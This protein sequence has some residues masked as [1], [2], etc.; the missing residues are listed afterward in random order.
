MAEQSFIQRFYEDVTRNLDD[1]S[2]SRRYPLNK[3]LQDLHDIDQRLFEDVLMLSGQE[4][5]AGFAESTI[6][7][8][9]NKEFYRLPEGFRQFLALEFRET[10]NNYVLARI[11]SG[12]FFGLKR[13]AQI[14]TSARGMRLTPAVLYS[15][16][17]TTEEWTLVYQRA[18]GYLH[19]AQTARVTAGSLTTGVP[20]EDGGRVILRDGY[21][22]GME[23]TVYD[24][25]GSPQTREVL[26][27]FVDKDGMT[28]QPRHNFDPTPEG[29]VWYELRPSVPERYDSIYA[30]DAAFLEMGRRKIEPSRELRRQREAL[31]NAIFKH[32]TSNVSDRGPE[33][34]IPPSRDLNMST[35]IPQ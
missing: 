8:E 2:T 18:P 17:A 19:Y 12:T 31:W 23:M 25:K 3:R 30:L 11:G 6:I 21:Y 10:E 9:H 32:F 1:A 34:I 13:R 16:E 28:L 29:K 14:L 4:S 20:P 33:R 26:N 5:H 15:D 27:S 22:N 7:L 35:E 24:G